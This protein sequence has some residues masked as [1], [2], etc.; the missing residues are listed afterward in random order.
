MSGKRGNG[1][2]NI[3]IILGL[4]KSVVCR[5]PNEILIILYRDSG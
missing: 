3:I 2:A 5:N 4:W 1:P